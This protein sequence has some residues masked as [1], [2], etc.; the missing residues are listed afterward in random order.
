MEAA[1]AAAAAAAAVVVVAVVVA[2]VVAA[3]VAVVVAAALG[4]GWACWPWGLHELTGPYQLWGHHE[5]RVSR[6]C[7]C[8]VA[9]Q[10]G[11]QQ[12]IEDL[13]GDPLKRDV[14][15]DFHEKFDW[16]PRLPPVGQRPRF[17]AGD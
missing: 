13:A 3:V 15:L 9:V 2:A 16:R 14:P 4:L 8:A 17:W 11:Q 1:A 10:Q 12:Y 7:L 5:V 6:R